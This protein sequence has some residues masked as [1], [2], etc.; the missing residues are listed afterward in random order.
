MSNV[1]NPTNIPGYI[2]DFI[3]DFLYPFLYYHVFDCISDLACNV[4]I[5]PEAEHFTSFFKF[6]GI[7][8]YMAQSSLAMQDLW[9]KQ[10]QMEQNIYHHFQSSVDA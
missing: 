8:V 3:L 6:L 7:Y 5:R 4:T 9:Q 10:N 2:F 1:N